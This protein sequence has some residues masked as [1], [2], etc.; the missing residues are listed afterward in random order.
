MRKSTLSIFTLLCFAS[1]F[2]QA[3]KEINFGL[4]GINYE[5]PVH[6][7]ITIAPGV[8]T[9]LDLDWLNAGVKG[10]YYFDHVFGITDDAW[11]V[12]GG[13]NVG[14]SFDLR[15][16]HDNNGH[17]GSD[18]N[19][20]LQ[21]GGRWFWNDKWGVYVEIGGGNVSGFSPGIGLTLKL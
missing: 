1:V 5:I 18:F 13:A 19:V 11:D 6:R 4:I 14:Y 16:D 8:G 12:Y 2:A 15:D 20:G 3:R 9:T 17:D 21:I 10:N 7:D